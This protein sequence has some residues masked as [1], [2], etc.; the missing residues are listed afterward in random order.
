MSNRRAIRGRAEGPAERRVASAG[1]PRRSEIPAPKG[2]V[3]AASEA[4][5]KASQAELEL[6]TELE[7]LRAAERERNAVLDA[8]PTPIAYF[9]RA[10][11][12]RLGNRAQREWYQIEDVIGLSFAEMIDPAIDQI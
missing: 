3:R 12:C 10:G 2:S 7:R 11:Q 1:V 9:D 6:N 4:A 8:V 5:P